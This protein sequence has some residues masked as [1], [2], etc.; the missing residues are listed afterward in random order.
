MRKTI[1]TTLCV[2]ICF[3]LVACSESNTNEMIDNNHFQTETQTQVENHIEE[4]T[5]NTSENNPTTQTQTTEPSND[6]P[7]INTDETQEGN[8]KIKL[9][10][11]DKE[12]EIAL[13][14]TPAANSLYEILPLNLTFEDFNN[15][16]KISYLTENLTTEGEPDGYEPKIRDFC[17]Y[18]PWGNLSIFYE[19]FQYSPSLI[20]LGHIDSN[21]D[22]EIIKTINS[23]FLARLEKSE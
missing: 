7:D 18:A 8:M 3:I 15:T 10:I 5:D 6:I 4:E 13:Y 21:S 2:F 19:N 14:N 12:I 22:I 16:E 9:I 23:D 1:I 17:L 11:E 20:L